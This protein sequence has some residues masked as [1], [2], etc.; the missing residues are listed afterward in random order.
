MSP[1]S[2][3]L[4]QY[5]PPVRQPTPPGIPSFGTRE[6]MLYSARLLDRPSSVR[7]Q[8]P[9]DTSTEQGRSATYGQAFRRFIGISPPPH[10]QQQRGLWTRAPDGT[11]VLGYFPH[12]HSAHGTNVGGRLETHPFHRRNLPLAAENGMD[13]ND[14]A[15]YGQQ[16]G[17][18]RPVLGQRVSTFADT[19]QRNWPEAP[20]INAYMP[21]FRDR[22]LQRAETPPTVDEPDDPPAAVFAPA[23]NT[24]HEQGTTPGDETN[25]WV[26]ISSIFEPCFCGCLDLRIQRNR[27]IDSRPGSNDTHTT[28][29]SRI[30]N[31]STGEPTVADAGGGGPAAQRFSEQ[32][33]GI[34]K[35]IKRFVAGSLLTV[36]PMLA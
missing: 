7:S 2:P 1:V 3:V 33:A 27:D 19:A 36:E 25:T 8:T 18:S 28:A 32:C 35:S 4:P 23:P 12:R 29:R 13:D 34:W 20:T 10:P 22:E 5:P 9:Q 15:K 17:T 31:Q 16:L 14:T 6:A 11:A 30:S 26:Q 21:I 24:P